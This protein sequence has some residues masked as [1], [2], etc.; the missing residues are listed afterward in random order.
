VQYYLDIAIEEGFAMADNYNFSDCLICGA[1]KAAEQK[2][3]SLSESELK[4][5]FKAQSQKQLAKAAKQ[6][7]SKTV[8][9]ATEA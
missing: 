4:R 3:R 6:R 1:I 7:P 8:N 2:G 9:M 5:A